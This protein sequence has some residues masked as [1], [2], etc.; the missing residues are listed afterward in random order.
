M[1]C[2]VRLCVCTSYCLYL[3]GFLAR[4]AF[5]TVMWMIISSIVSWKCPTCWDLLLQLLHQCFHLDAGRW[6][7]A[8]TSTTSTSSVKFREHWVS[9]GGRYPCSFRPRTV[10]WVSSLSTCSRTI[11]SGSN[12]IFQCAGLCVQGTRWRWTRMR[13]WKS[14][15]IIL[16]QPMKSKSFPLQPTIQRI[17]SPMFMP[18]DSGC[19]TSS[20]LCSL[21][22]IQEYFRIDPSEAH[23]KG[24]WHKNLCFKK[25]G[26]QLFLQVGFRSKKSLSSRSWQ[27][28]QVS[29]C[30]WFLWLV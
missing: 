3:A 24:F 26:F 28:I 11:L 4:E 30:E 6:S 29:T 23:S 9:C 18:H 19:F 15:Q 21:H 5:S 14:V 16:F 8:S 10:Y 12:G 25:Q 7:S 17:L 20:K 1:L 22:K 27:A 13:H 2:T